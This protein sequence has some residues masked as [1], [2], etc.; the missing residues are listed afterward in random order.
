LV[1]DNELN[2]ELAIEFLKKA[3]IQLVTALNG[4]EAI[5]ILEEDAIGFDGVLMDCQMPVMDGYTASRLIRMDAR[6][7]DLPIIAMTANNMAGDRERCI[8]AGMTDHISK[9]L[10]LD[11]MFATLS[12]WIKPRVRTGGALP[13]TP[14]PSQADPLPGIAQPSVLVSEAVNP[15]LYRRILTKFRDRYRDFGDLFR[16]AQSDPDPQAAERCAHSLKGLAATIGAVATREAAAVLEDLCRQ[17]AEPERIAAQ[18]KA[19]LAE[20]DPVIGGLEGLD[21]A[22]GSEGEPF[23]ADIMMMLAQLCQWLDE[24]DSRA[25]E[26]LERIAPELGV[27][28]RASTVRKLRAAVERFDFEPALQY[29]RELA[30]VAE[31][32]GTPP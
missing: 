12:A 4:Q 26:L 21:R 32:M 31:S 20:L 16:A 5:D 15:T 28:G 8:E 7:K 6:W 3:G 1:E 22:P 9:P 27:I 11:R 13:P 23:G 30:N 18:L 10:D 2:Q 14:P 24:G 29:A 25:L 19:T 17:G